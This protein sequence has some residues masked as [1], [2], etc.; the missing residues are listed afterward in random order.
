MHVATG[1]RREMRGHVGSRV[2]LFRL[3]LRQWCSGAAPS[4]VRPAEASTSSPAGPPKVRL[5]DD[6]LSTS[7][8]APSRLARRGLARGDSSSSGNDT[9]LG[10]LAQS[11]LRARVVARGLK[12]QLAL[13]SWRSQLVSP[14]APAPPPSAS[15]AHEAPVRR[16]RCFP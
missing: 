4:G 16:F 3:L 7:A 2:A 1:E 6:I 11:S 13:T 14:L 10:A 5:A 15:V 12:A 9:A 8:S